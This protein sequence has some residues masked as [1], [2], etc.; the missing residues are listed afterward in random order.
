M[1]TVSL[2][3]ARRWRALSFSWAFVFCLLAALPA[4]LARAAACAADRIDERAVVASVYDGD[5][6]RLRDR[7]T[8]RLI[9]INTPELPARGEKGEPQPHAIEAR[10]ALRALLPAGAEVGLR[11]DEEMRDRHGRLL[12]HVYTAGGASAQAR[13]LEDGHAFQIVVPPNGWN[14][15]CYRAAEARARA[16]GRGIWALPDYRPVEVA[17]LAAGA[18]GFH[19]LRGKVRNVDE[20]SSGT[21]WLDMDNGISVRIDGKDL[22]NFRGM[23]LARLRG[24]EIVVRG[25][26][27][28]REGKRAGAVMALR[29]PAALEL[30]DA[31]PGS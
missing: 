24:R 11:F 17:R 12:A 5:T 20:S 15:E 2:R 31:Q 30:A 7:R 16:G 6:L 9:G 27:T 21:W 3:R 10:D 4:G 25:W 8:V 22:E 18:S 28:P 26:L 1:R 23:P 19:R 14:L 29:H 13:M